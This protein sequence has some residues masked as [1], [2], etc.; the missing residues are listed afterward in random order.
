MGKPKRAVRS[1]ARQEVRRMERDMRQMLESE[2]EARRNYFFP[3][4]GTGFRPAG[5]TR[6]KESA[7]NEEK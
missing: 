7:T 5:K 3:E 2:T 6:L 1:T 4:Q